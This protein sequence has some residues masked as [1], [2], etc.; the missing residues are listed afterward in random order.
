[1]VYRSGL[2]SV[3]DDCTDACSERV[4]GKSSVRTSLCYINRPYMHVNIFLEVLFKLC[5]L[6]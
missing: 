2:C 4:R 1:M 3:G 6:I 5:S